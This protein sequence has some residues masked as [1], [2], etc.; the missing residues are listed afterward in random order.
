LD[1]ADLS[2]RNEQ[3]SGLVATGGLGRVFRREHARGFGLS[4]A[5]VDA[6]EL[7]GTLVDRPEAAVSRVDGAA[8]DRQGAG[9][10]KEILGIGEGGG[11]GANGGQLAIEALQDDGLQ[12]AVS[13]EARTERQRAERREQGDEQPAAEGKPGAEELHA[14]SL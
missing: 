13:D 4:G 5:G 7:T 6:D 8:A 12:S 14:R 1:R 3:S 11:D 10:G 2:V 9:Q